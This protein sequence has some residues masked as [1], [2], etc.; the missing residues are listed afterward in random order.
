V[1]RAPGAGDD[2]AQTARESILGVFEHLVG[3]A[4]GGQHAR[5]V[6]NAES[7]ELRDRVLHGLPVALAAHHHPG[8]R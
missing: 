5:L 1:R 6:G 3:H 2:D 4:V 8:Q 7:V